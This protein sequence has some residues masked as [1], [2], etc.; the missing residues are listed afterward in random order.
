MCQL[1]CIPYLHYL[2]NNSLCLSVGDCLVNHGVKRRLLCLQCLPHRLDEV[3]V[4]GGFLSL[5]KLHL[6][7]QVCDLALVP[8]DRRREELK[9]K[10]EGVVVGWI[11]PGKFG[12]Q[13]S[14]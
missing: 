6:M 8:L 1:G 9:N 4:G 2:S 3:M 12:L 14:V 10:E 7:T 13:D 11:S 5:E